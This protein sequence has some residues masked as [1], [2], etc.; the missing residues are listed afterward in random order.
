MQLRRGFLCLSKQEE[1]N[2]KER[3]YEYGDDG[4]DEEYTAFARV[5]YGIPS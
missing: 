4:E 3:L 1:S 5:E 2:R